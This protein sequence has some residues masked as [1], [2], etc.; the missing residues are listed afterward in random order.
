M[1]I[2]IP[3]LHIIAIMFLMGSL[4]TEHL[5]LKPVMTREQ[6]KSLVAVDTVYGLSA[7]VVL[8]TGLLRWFV[9]GRGSAYYLGNPLFHTKLTLFVI[10]AL[11]SIFPTIQ[12]LKWRKQVKAGIDPAIGVR[13]VKGLLMYIRIEMLILALIPLLAVMIARGYGVK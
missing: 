10:V 13:Q 6:I 3:Y 11:L 9:Y 5:I 7:A 4:I 1:F 8:I 12:F 2:A